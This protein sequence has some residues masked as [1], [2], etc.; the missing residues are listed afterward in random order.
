MTFPKSL[1]LYILPALFIIAATVMGVSDILGRDS[2]IVM[3]D[4]TEIDVSD[5]DTRDH[6]IK[7]WVCRGSGDH[8][9]AYILTLLNPD[10]FE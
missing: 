9:G 8:K 3:K 1:F 10:S 5:M 2:G 7:A 4:C 6:V